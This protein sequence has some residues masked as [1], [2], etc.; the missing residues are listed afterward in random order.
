MLPST[1]YAETYVKTIQLDD[2]GVNTSTDGEIKVSTLNRWEKTRKRSQHKEQ[3][4]I[5]MNTKTGSLIFASANDHKNE[6]SRIY[7]RIVQ[8]IIV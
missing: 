2:T 5:Y 3:L 7:M 1:E 6:C 4:H 8:Y